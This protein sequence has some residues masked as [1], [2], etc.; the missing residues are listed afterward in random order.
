MHSAHWAIENVIYN[1]YS[2]KASLVKNPGDTDALS[3]VQA[4]EESLVEFCKNTVK[5][6]YISLVFLEGRKKTAKEVRDTLGIS[7]NSSIG[8]KNEFIYL[9]GR[10]LGRFD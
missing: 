7:N 8:W 5:R 2:L 1:Y 4:I 6:E 10:K 3:K 9:V